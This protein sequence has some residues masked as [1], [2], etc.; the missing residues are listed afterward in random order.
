MLLFIIFFVFKQKTAYEMR[1]SDWSSDV[2][3]SDL[4]DSEVRQF[5]SNGINLSEIEGDLTYGQKIT[6]ARGNLFSSQIDQANQ[7]YQN[8]QVEE[9]PGSYFAH[10]LI[11]TD[12]MDFDSIANG[13]NG[14]IIPMVSKQYNIPYTVFASSS[15]DRKSVV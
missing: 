10:F 3:S 4:I 6:I 2:C 13:T 7:G 5:D 15:R 1:I 14:T 8:F 11:E 12:G 9:A